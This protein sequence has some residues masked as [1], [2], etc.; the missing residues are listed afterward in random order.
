MKNVDTIINKE[1]YLQWRAEWRADYAKLSQRIRQL[2]AVRRF[3][4]IMRSS[5][6]T[7][8]FTPEDVAVLHKLE[9]ELGLV[10]NVYG[11]DITFT[12]HGHIAQAK[13]MATAMLEAR[14]ASKEAAERSYEAAK[15][16]P[17]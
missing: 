8:R 3:Q 7:P 9:K 2:K 12:P 10:Q 16:L 14:K 11:K 4:D 13:E 6:K 5:P 17:A 15:A 1:T